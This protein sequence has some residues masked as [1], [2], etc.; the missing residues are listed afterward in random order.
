MVASPYDDFVCELNAE[1]EEQVV[2]QKDAY[3]VNQVS[4]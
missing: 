1:Y 2:G 3:H 4:P